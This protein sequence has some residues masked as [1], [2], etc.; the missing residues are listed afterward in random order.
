MGKSIIGVRLRFENGVVV[1]ATAAQG[2]DYLEKLLNMDEGARRLG[3]F[4]FG[5]NRN[6]DRCTKNILFDEKIGGTIDNL[7]LM[8]YYNYTIKKI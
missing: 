6:V 1:E 8:T 5:N 3:E 7:I 4:A 2:Q